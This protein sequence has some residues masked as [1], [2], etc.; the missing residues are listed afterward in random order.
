MSRTSDRAFSI[1]KIIMTLKA[2]GTGYIE[3][4]LTAQAEGNCQRE[5]T[6][7]MHGNLI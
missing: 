5:Q 2:S 3:L 1:F 6:L 7:V 4:F